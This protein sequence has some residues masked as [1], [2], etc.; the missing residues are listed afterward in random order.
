MKTSSRR[1]AWGVSASLVVLGMLVLTFPCL[2]TC[3]IGQSCNI[4]L[5]C[6][7]LWFTGLVLVVGGTV[8]AVWLLVGKL[9]A[10]AREPQA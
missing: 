10:R 4:P 7:L 5:A 1:I 3:L 8:S 6:A 9:R 2:V